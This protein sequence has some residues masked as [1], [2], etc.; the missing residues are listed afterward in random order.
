MKDIHLNKHPYKVP[1]VKIIDA[2][3]EECLLMISN[4]DGAEVD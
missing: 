3:P 4:Y 1:A 2:I